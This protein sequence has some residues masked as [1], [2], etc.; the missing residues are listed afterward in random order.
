M[1]REYYVYAMD[2]TQA[3]EADKHDDFYRG[4]T[5]V[6]LDSSAQD[7]TDIVDNFIAARP[8]F[9]TGADGIPAT[10]W[11][12]SFDREGTLFA[13]EYIPQTPVAH[14]LHHFFWCPMVLTPIFALISRPGH[15]LSATEIADL[16][17]EAINR[18]YPAEEKE[19]DAKNDI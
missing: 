5:V 3:I 2:A 16:G 18:A 19:D 14:L 6:T 17:R 11:Y 4:G 15:P 13:M 10:G 9:Q 12:V 8:A 7:V 1:V